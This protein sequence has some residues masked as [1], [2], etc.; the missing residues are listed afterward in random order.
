MPLEEV[1]ENLP[2]A[3]EKILAMK[4]SQALVARFN[5]RETLIGEDGSSDRSS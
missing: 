4:D 1:F 3:K 2:V 5:W